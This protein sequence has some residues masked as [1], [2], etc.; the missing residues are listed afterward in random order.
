MSSES[1]NFLAIDLGASSGRTMVGSWDGARLELRELHRFANGAVNV[2]GHLH[3]D[4]LQLWTEI[5][6]GLARYAAD[7][8]APLAGIGVDTW[9]VDFALLD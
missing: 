4:A 7:D 6:N 2:L 5:K 3:W 8:A 1:T 9:G